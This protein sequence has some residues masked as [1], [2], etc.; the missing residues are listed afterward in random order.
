[1]YK[2]KK[3]GRQ[4]GQK[5]VGKEHNMKLTKVSTGIEYPLQSYRFIWEDGKAVGFGRMNCPEDI[6]PIEW[7]NRLDD[8]IDELWDG[9]GELYQDEDGNLYGVETMHFNEKCVPCVWSRVELANN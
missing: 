2:I 4:D 1:M 8:Y 7:E 6:N 9:Y 5:P 3:K